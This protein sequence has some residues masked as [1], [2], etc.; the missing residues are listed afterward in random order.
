MAGE[1]LL[2]NPSLFANKQN[3]ASD[4]SLAY[5]KLFQLNSGGSNGLS[6]LKSFL[7]RVWK[8]DLKNNMAMMEK[9]G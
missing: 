7:F 4:E 3:L 1:G 9:L 6:S 8:S 2:S 5:L